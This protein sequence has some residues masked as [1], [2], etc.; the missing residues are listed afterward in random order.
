M[1]MLNIKSLKFNSAL[2]PAIGVALLPKL[3]CPAC[4]PAYA[5]L[6]SSLGIGF[7]DYTPYLVPFTLVFLAISLGTMVYRAKSRN[8]YGPLSLGLLAGTVL[9][10]GKFVFDSDA[11]MYVGLAVL[12]VASLW[13]SWPRAQAD[14]CQNCVTK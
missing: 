6:L 12:V 1:N 11:A 10:I 9:M 14:T 5:G 4:W 3:T 8:G 7:V 13:N 2:V